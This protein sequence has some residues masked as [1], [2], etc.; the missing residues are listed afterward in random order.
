MSFPE[1]DSAC[2]ESHVVREFES[3]QRFSE[4][5]CRGQLVKSTM[6]TGGAA[7]TCLIDVCHPRNSLS[8]RF[9]IV[10]DCD[11]LFLALK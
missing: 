1:A 9:N 4:K 7:E 5:D 10:S 2:L 6:G 3:T 11:S 8:L